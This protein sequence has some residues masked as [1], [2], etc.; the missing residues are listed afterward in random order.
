MWYDDHKYIAMVF[1]PIMFALFDL[2]VCLV[3]LLMAYRSDLEV[4]AMSSVVVILLMLSY[5]AGMSGV[6]WYDFHV[7]LQA[8][9][10][11]EEDAEKEAE[12]IHSP[13]DLNQC[14]EDGHHGLL[15]LVTAVMLVALTALTSSDSK[16]R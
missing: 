11:L 9:E 7:F 2:F 16:L 10:G 5:I 1:P 12:A 13:V 3:V 14:F 6:L 4:Y 15:F 8:S